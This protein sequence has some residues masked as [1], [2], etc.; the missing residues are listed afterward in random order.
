VV[1]VR[2]SLVDLID[3]ALP[4][5]QCQRCG[6]DDC[7]RYAAAVATDA[8]P[9]NQCPPGGAEG[10]ARLAALTGAA[11][12]ALDPTRGSEGPLRNARIDE[13]NCI[14]CTL[15]LDACPVDCIVGGP[16]SLHTVI[17]SLCTGCD[18]CLPVCPVDCIVMNSVSEHRTGW[19]AW[20][21]AQ[22]NT[23][24]QRY[25]IHQRRTLASEP[26]TE[27]VPDPAPA[28]LRTGSGSALPTRPNQLVAAVLA[29]VRRGRFD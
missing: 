13:A 17:E 24:R 20:S 23:A 22:A 7:R 19:D 1:S 9:I 14:G 26:D 11:R 12:I 29:R 28:G 3:A 6:Y 15:C 2:D 16:K 10:V 21:Q 8:A 5:T 27:P 25:A 18:L 4:Q